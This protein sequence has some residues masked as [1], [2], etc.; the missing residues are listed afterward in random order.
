MSSGEVS[1]LINIIFLPFLP[2]ASAFS[3]EKT[4]LPLDAPG[5]AGK[6]K[7]TGEFFSKSSVTIFF[8][9]LSYI[10]RGLTLNKASFFDIRRSS[11]MSVAIFIDA[12]PV[13]LPVLV[14]SIQSFL[15][16]MVNSISCMSLKCFS[17]FVL[18]L[19]SFVNAFGIDLSKD[20]SDPSFSKIGLGV[21][22]PATTSSPCA[23]S[24]HSP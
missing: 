24:N 13:L 8:K 7:E 16:S 20:F 4:T 6:P 1:S 18:M 12:I 11:T 14:W 2:K 17:S 15:F 5:P 21:L 23:S 19:L 10:C 22:R 9:R 3:A